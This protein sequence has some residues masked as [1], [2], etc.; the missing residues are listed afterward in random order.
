MVAD[1]SHQMFVR[2]QLL[3]IQNATKVLIN[4]LDGENMVKRHYKLNWKRLK[5]EESGGA[6]GQ[7]KVH[8]G[9]YH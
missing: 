1:L 5:E 4:G 3:C 8:R 6:I 2:L 9:E 7:E